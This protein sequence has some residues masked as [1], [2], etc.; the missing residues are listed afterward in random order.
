MVC[1]RI[2]ILSQGQESGRMCGS[3]WVLS[4]PLVSVRV[5]W[6]GEKILVFA[7]CQSNIKGIQ[8]SVCVEL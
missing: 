8:C 5:V 3:D 2:S 7:L 6:H 1:F 4:V